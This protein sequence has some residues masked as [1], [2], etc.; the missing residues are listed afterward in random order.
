MRVFRRTSLLVPAIGAAMLGAIAPGV[1]EAAPS[2][3]KASWNSCFK[4]FGPSFQC[5]TVQV[6][7][8]YDGPMDATIRSRWCGSRPQTRPGGSARSSSTPAAP[9]DQAW[10]SRCSPDR[11]SSRRRSAPASISWASTRGVSPAD[12]SSLL[13]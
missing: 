13:R 11:S 4:E 9:A 1:V 5:A 2:I 3:P 7:L 12:G 10:N 8:D 6:P